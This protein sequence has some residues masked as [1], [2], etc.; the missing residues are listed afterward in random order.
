MSFVYLMRP[1]KG[2]PALGEDVLWSIIHVSTVW[3]ESVQTEWY[4][5]LTIPGH[6]PCGNMSYREEYTR[7]FHVE[8]EGE[9]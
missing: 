1:C 7:T 4:Q 2:C 6:C 8:A 5:L 9:S 3:T